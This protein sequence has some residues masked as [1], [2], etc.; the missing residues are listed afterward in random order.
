MS[1]CANDFWNPISSFVKGKVDSISGSCEVLG[2]G[3]SWVHAGGSS[4][5]WPCPCHTPGAKWSP[6]ETWQP[7]IGK[8][9]LHCVRISLWVEWYQL[10]CLWRFRNTVS[11]VIKVHLLDGW[12]VA[13]G[14]IMNQVLFLGIC[15]YSTLFD[16]QVNVIGSRKNFP[17]K[18]LRH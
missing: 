2:I 8:K 5:P 11:Q 16:R 17:P 14:F 4:L 1:S 18:C 15:P 6:E 12:Q 10:G 3:A 9:L 13:L 7:D